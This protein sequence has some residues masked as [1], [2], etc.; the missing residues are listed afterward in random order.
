MIRY[1]IIILLCLLTLEAQDNG[2]KTPKINYN[3]KSYL[4]L[5]AWEPLEIDGILEEYSWMVLPWR[6][7][8][9]DIEGVDNSLKNT[10]FKMLWDDQYLYIATEFEEEDIWGN[11][12]TRDEM[13]Y[14]DNC[15]EIFIDPDNDNYNYYECQINALGTICDLFMKKPYRDGNG[16]PLVNYNLKGLKVAVNI[17]GTI[18]NSSDKDKKWVLEIAVPWNSLS[19]ITGRQIPP[20]ENDQWKINLARV[21][22]DIEK[23]EKS[24]KKIT[25]SKTGK[26]IPEKYYT[27]SPQGLRNLHFPEMWGLVQFS[28]K[29]AHETPADSILINYEDKAKW[30]LMNVYYQQKNYYLKNKKYTSDINNLK[31]ESVG[32]EFYSWPPELSATEN[33]F[34]AAIYSVNGF[35]KI[36]INSEGQLRKFKAN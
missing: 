18:N 28:Y 13:L 10:K 14:I 12:Q 19:E 30:A 3:P 4:C 9:Q 17:D 29:L 26:I 23:S 5:R 7:D 1:W 36:T 16:A 22:W 2:F 33:Y 21:D 27:W 34:E 24:Y 20:M 8:F 15:L 35:E 25:D 32:P 6:E 31:I 11:I